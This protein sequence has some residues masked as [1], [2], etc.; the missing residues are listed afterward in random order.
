VGRFLR[1]FVAVAILITTTGAWAQVAPRTSQKQKL[2]EAMPHLKKGVALYDEND[3]PNALIE[4]KRAYE[5]AQEWKFLFNLAQTAYQVHDYAL[6][7][8]SFQSYLTDG[9]AA[10][11]RSRKTF[12]EGEITK[13]KGLVATV[14]VTVSAPNADVFVDDEKV[15]TSPLSQPITVSAGRRKI[16]AT[17]AGK[18]ATKSFEVAGGDSTQVSLD[19]ESEDVQKPPPPPPPPIETRR[20]IPWA[21]WGAAGG[22]LVVWGATGAVALVFSSDAQ[23]KLNTYGVT[24]A[25]IKSAQD[26]AKA[27]AIVSDIALGCTVIAAGVATVMTILAKPEPVEKRASAHFV[28]SPFGVGVYGSF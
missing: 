14:R 26:S 3:Y 4:F 28:A 24:A 6:A 13:L 11:E 17:L 27:F 22:L 23:S 10:V 1:L 25:Q 7:L 8:T 9:G 16:S 5:I 12:V 2:E 19:I 18:T 21:A 15:G 20:R